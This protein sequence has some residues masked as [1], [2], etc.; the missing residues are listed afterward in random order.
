MKTTFGRFFIMSALGVGLIQSPL[1]ARELSVNESHMKERI[2]ALS[3]GEGSVA[4]LRIE[5]YDGGMAA[6]R[7]Y[8]IADEKI[9]KRQWNLAR[10]PEKHDELIVTDNQIRKLLRDLVEKQYWTFQGTRF[11]PDNT[12]F[13][14]RFYDKDLPSVD[15]RCDVNE[16]E[17]S[18]ERSAIRSVLLN[19]V[20]TDSVGLAS[21]ASLSAMNQAAI[22]D[23]VQEIVVRALDFNQDDRESLTDA[24]ADF[25]P[26]D[27]SEFIKHIGG[28][29]DDKGAPTFSSNFTP[30]G[31][32][33]DI[34]QA[35]G[36]IRF[37]IPGILKQQSRNVSGGVSTTTYRAEIDAQAVGDPVKIE[38]LK[39]RTCGGASTVPSCR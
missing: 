2:T 22:V 6:H 33:L 30:S 39:P 9:I 7:S 34:S 15:Y 14:F 32:A 20:T 17:S 16:Y 24:Q 36:V 13:L 4:D 11:I 31:S 38:Y 12:I 37:T 28:W 1:A 19:F 23:S 8:L 35:N 26:D 5:L 10:P 27:W 29:L 25:T 3:Q 18:P 21:S